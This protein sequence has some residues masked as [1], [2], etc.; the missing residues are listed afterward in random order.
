MTWGSFFSGFAA[1]REPYSSRVRAETPW[2]GLCAA[3]VS[4]MLDAAAAEPTRGIELSNTLSALVPRAQSTKK[5]FLPSSG[6]RAAMKRN[7]FSNT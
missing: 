7:G 2:R 4:V 1:R 5:P 6:L 3:T